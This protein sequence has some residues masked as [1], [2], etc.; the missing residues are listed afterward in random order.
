MRIVAVPTQR[1]A[2]T[3]AW[4]WQKRYPLA[5]HHTLDE[6]AEVL[7]TTTVQPSDRASAKQ[8]RAF[9]EAALDARRD[10]C[11]G[12]VACVAQEAGDHPEEFSRRMRWARGAVAAAFGL[13]TA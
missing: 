4:H 7:F 9:V 2:K 1:T 13:V 10:D 11:A 12:C 8:V 6:L 3:A 5:S